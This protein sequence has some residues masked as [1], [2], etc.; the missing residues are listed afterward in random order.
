MDPLITNAID[1]AL[2]SVIDK[3]GQERDPQPGRKRAPALELSAEENQD[4]DGES[5]TDNGAEPNSPKHE[6]DDLA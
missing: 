6:L 3:R 4:G 2:L 5:N 1:P